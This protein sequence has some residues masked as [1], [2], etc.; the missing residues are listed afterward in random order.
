ME[1]RVLFNRF[2]LCQCVF[3]FFGPGVSTGTVLVPK[4]NALNKLGVVRCHF[5][6]RLLQVHVFYCRKSLVTSISRDFH[7]FNFMDFK[8]A[9]L[10]P[11]SR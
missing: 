11:R 2:W 7:V 9:T 6:W 3:V 4:M 8:T 10:L 1:L 5:D